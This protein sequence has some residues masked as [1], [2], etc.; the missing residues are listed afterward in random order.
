MFRVVADEMELLSL[1]VTPAWRRQ[2]LACW[3]T[4]LALAV[5][6]RKGARAAFLEVRSANAPA[7]RL[8]AS[9]GFVETGR[10]PG[11]YQDPVE[12]AIVLSR[13]FGNGLLNS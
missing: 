5:A 9:L 4:R 3:L 1:A 13:T 6:G 11:Y 8:Y 2:G 10:R 12:D 7:R